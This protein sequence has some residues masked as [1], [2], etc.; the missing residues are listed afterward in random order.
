MPTVHRQDGYRF[1]FHSHEPNEPPHVHIDA[2][3]A[4]AKLWLEPPA[5]ARNLGFRAKELNAI[6]RLV[7]EH[8]EMLVEAWHGHFGTQRR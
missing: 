1:Y 7:R 2:A 5:V 8:R 4:T 6:L 3:G